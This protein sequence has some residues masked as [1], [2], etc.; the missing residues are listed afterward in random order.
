MGLRAHETWLAMAST[1][2]IF[3]DD[4]LE[5]SRARNAT[6]SL[7]RSC[8]KAEMTTASET[9]SSSAVKGYDNHRQPAWWHT[10]KQSPSLFFLG[11]VE[12]DLDRPRAVAMEVILESD[13]RAVALLPQRF[14]A[15]KSTPVW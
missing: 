15:I 10:S 3:S 2:Q 11:E 4:V 9:G 6:T 5:F 14:Q 8:G 12:K 1:A 7:S 13:D